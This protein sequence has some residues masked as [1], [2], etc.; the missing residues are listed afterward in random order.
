MISN[1]NLLVG[2]NLEVNPISYIKVSV[3]PMSISML[4]HSQLSSAEVMLE[5]LKFKL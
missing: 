2:M 1:S 5:Q 4:L 3:S